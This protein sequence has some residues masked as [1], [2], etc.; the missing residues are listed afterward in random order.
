MCGDGHFV[1]PYLFDQKRSLVNDMSTLLSGGKGAYNT[2]VEC[3]SNEI[4]MHSGQW[5]G[6]VN[7]KSAP[8]TEEKDE[9]HKPKSAPN[10]FGAECQPN[11]SSNQG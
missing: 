8:Q 9:G 7:V 10:L 6:P 4:W 11:S 2:R 3:I 5:K 1:K